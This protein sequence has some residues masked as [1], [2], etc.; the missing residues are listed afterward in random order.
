MREHLSLKSD[1]IPLAHRADKRAQGRCDIRKR[2]RYQA[3][4]HAL[5]RRAIEAEVSDRSPH[6]AP[7]LFCSLYES[8]TGVS[9]MGGEARARAPV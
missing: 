4:I 8:N 5:L 3:Y 6:V 1:D 2:L 7:R 9:L